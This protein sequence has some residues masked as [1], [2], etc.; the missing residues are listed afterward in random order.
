MPRVSRAI[1]RAKKAAMP[2]ED[3]G[4]KGRARYDRK[5]YDSILAGYREDPGNHSH[6]GRYAGVDRLMA[7]G[8]WQDGFPRQFAAGG[9]WARPIRDVLAEERDTALRRLQELR[10]RERAAEDAG[11]EKARAESIEE[12]AEEGR[13]RSS[14]R[15]SVL[16]MVLVQ[17]ELLP[18]A[19]A[20]VGVI[21]SAVM[22]KDANGNWVARAK[23]DLT[24]TQASRMLRD[25]TNNV[26]RLTASAQTMIELGRLV[27]GESTLNVA[28]VRD[29]S[30]EEAIEELEMAA[31]VLAH[32][33][34]ARIRALS[35]GAPPLDVEGVDVTDA[36][37]ADT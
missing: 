37:D 6:A 24:P 34:A 3:P 26:G 33:R 11:R 9:L 30:P 14:V 13:L 29:A 35:A 7:R 10:E 12:L 32:V 15:K 31:D 25:A 20:C 19:R 28:A 17:Q 2:G 18:A 23:P 16:G 22:E 8:A 4:R 5:T 21:R 27:R 36:Q 1:Q